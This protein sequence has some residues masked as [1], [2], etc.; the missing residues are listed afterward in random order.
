M[1]LRMPFV[2]VAGNMETRSVRAMD[3]QG[4]CKALETSKSQNPALME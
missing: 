2:H 1:E 3:F 4:Y